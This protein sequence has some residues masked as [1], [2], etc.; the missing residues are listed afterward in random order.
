MTLTL[1]VE[2][3]STFFLILSLLLL[4]AVLLKHFRGMKLPAHWVYYL[5]A[6]C[7]LAISSAST[8]LLNADF[9]SVDVWLRFVANLSILLGSYEIFKRYESRLSSKLSKK[10]VKKKR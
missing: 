3:I 7:L 4:T 1:I 10:H 9:A 8:R 2:F 5:G 6:F